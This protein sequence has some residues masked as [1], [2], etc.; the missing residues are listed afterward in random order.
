[1]EVWDEINKLDSASEGE[2]DGD[3]EDEVCTTSGLGI[4]LW[5]V[6]YHIVLCRQYMRWCGGGDLVPRRIWSLK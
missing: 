1:M 2:E 3:D 4:V 5:D 6:S